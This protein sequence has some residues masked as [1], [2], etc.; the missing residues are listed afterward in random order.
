MMTPDDFKALRELFDSI[1]FVGG[2]PVP[3]TYDEA[4]GGD[5]EDGED[6]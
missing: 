2:E 4:Y 5:D 1:S 3:A 6:D